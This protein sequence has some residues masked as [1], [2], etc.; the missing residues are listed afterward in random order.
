M[1][2]NARR[3]N[4]IR[5]HFL[6]LY[7]ELFEFYSGLD[8][9]LFDMKLSGLTLPVPIKRQIYN[10]KHDARYCEDRVTELKRIYALLYT[11]GYRVRPSNTDLFCWYEQRDPL[12][13]A[14]I[15]ENLCLVSSKYRDEGRY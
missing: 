7:M 10:A 9:K 14:V 5:M 4:P 11:D 2:G 1:T 15:Q 8:V 13:K 6:M 12:K 3:H